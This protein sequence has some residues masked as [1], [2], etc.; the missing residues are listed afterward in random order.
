MIQ[1]KLSHGFRNILV[2]VGW[3]FFYKILRI[4]VEP[5][6]WVLIA[7]YLGPEQ[8]G[9]YNYALS[10]VALFNV[11]TGLGLR[12]LVVRDLV[13]HPGDKNLLLGTAFALKLS[14]GL[15]SLL[16]SIGIIWLSKPNDIGIRSLVTIFAIS[17]IFQISSTINIWFESQ[18]KSKITAYTTITA[19]I[20]IVIAKILL[21]ITNAPLLAFA[22]ITVL[23][24][25]IET[26]GAIIAYRITGELIQTWRASL[27][28]AKAMLNQSWPL[29]LAGIGTIFY[30]KID[31]IMLGEIS[32]IKE[33]G[34]YSAAI[35]F[36]E[37]LYF[38]PSIITNTVFP[39]LV[40]NK[41]DDKKIY[42]KNLQKLYNYMTWTAIIITILGASFAHPLIVLLYGEEYQAAGIILAIHT[43]SNIFIFWHQINMDW[44]VNEGLLKFPLFRQIMGAIANIS[45]N[46]ILI[47]KYGGV[48]AAI[49]TVISYGIASYFAF[50]L[51]SKTQVAAKM[52]TLSLAFPFIII[53]RKISI[54]KI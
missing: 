53:W 5:L 54:D 25:F 13:Q 9:I 46:F 29:I 39:A 35:R 28:K 41:I 1:S 42:Q 50:F 30:L 36:S 38:V 14:G 43:W 18:I 2:N 15:L 4:V 23:Q 24:V 32:G 19:F 52:M 6:V 7:R 45:L 26:V 11:L 20:I 31:Q 27:S 37:A 21:L 47:P 10:F 33:V 22:Y 12:P 16:L 51:T 34:I 40:K 49:A 8:L 3:Q 17:N 48:G 44:L